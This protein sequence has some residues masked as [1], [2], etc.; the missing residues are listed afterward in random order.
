MIKRLFIYGGY[1]TNEGIFDDFNSLPLPNSGK[2]FHW[3]N[4][5]KKSENRRP[6]GNDEVP[7]PLRNHTAAVH[8]TKMYIFGGKENLLS[9]TGKLWI[10]DFTEYLWT[11]G[12]ECEI[13]GKQL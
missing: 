3:N 5:E 8:E 6:D 7:G 13:D 1:E 11:Y 9:P 10:F 12:G 4:I 2:P